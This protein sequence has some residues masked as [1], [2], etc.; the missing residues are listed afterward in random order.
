MSLLCSRQL[1]ESR[2]GLEEIFEH[3]G[4]PQS[5]ASRPM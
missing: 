1:T 5:P 4:R 2:A 3:L